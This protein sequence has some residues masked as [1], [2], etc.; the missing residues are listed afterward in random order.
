[1]GHF[2]A[3]LPKQGLEEIL[4]TMLLLSELPL[5]LGISPFYYIPGMKMTVP[6]IP[7]N[8][9]EAR[10]TRFWP[11]DNLLNE[12]DLITLFRLSRWLNYLKNE[13]SKK[14]LNKIHFSDISNIFPHDPYIHGLVEKHIFHGLDSN[15]TLFV[16]GHSRQ[17][18][19]IFHNIFSNTYV[20][21]AN[22]GI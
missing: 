20:Y 9:K 2:I 16:H 6:S 14:G 12:L 18:L 5:I 10:L 3:G 7:G 8:C 4:E 19:E 15:S 13:L 21:C 11:A 17:V 22:N 1:M